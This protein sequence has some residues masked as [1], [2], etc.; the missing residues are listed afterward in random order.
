[1]ADT[2]ASGRSYSETFVA[3]LRKTRFE[4]F[5][6]KGIAKINDCMLLAICACG[7]AWAQA[8]YPARPVRIVTA[9]AGGASDFA[10][11]D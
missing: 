8:L 9:A 3:F 10:A 7:A 1:M 5:P 2:V 11:R 6:A 4:N